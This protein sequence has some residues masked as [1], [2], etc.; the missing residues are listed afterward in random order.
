QLAELQHLIDVVD[1]LLER[2]DRRRV[3]PGQG[4]K[5]H[6]GDLGRRAQRELALELEEVGDFLVTFPELVGD[7]DADRQLALE[8]V[9]RVNA[10]RYRPDFAPAPQR[11]L[12]VDGARIFRRH[13]LRRRYQA[14]L[15]RRI[16]ALDEGQRDETREV[17]GLRRARQRE[18]GFAHIHVEL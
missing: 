10:D 14:V 1:V 9:T 3:E 8:L 2:A 15:D 11:M 4:G 17:D 18:A 7:P 13:R 6:V 16:D 5:A 12:V